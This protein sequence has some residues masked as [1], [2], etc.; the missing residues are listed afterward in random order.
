MEKI[1]L[2][3]KVAGGAYFLTLL[4]SISIGVIVLILR[5]VISNRQEEGEHS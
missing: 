3:F 5:K 2:A 1:I 4:V